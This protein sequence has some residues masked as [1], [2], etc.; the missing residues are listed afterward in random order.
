[1]PSEDLDL[2]PGVRE[3]IRA[4]EIFRQGVKEELAARTAGSRETTLLDRLNQ[5]ITLWF[6]SSIVLG[7]ISFAYAHWEGARAA[8]VTRQTEITKL[9]V[10]ISGRIS[11]SA[12]R[13]ESARNHVGLR[14][15]VQMLDEGSGV[16][17]EL[18]E[19]SFEGILLALSWLVSEEERDALG[20]ARQ[21][22]DE[23]QELRATDPTEAAAGIAEMKNVHLGGA[24]DIRR[25][26]D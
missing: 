8:A 2:P 23:L 19:R 3:R 7:A 17:P 20:A 4:E 15:A 22:Y 9:D 12:S 18:S 11:R 6:L 26:N 21:S 13:L 10:E 14:E 24:L 5:P 16:F 1:M 25:W